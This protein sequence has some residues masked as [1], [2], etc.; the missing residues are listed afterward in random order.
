MGEPSR[1]MEPPR[2]TM[3]R[4]SRGG[5][6]WGE[7]A[8]TRLSAI[9][10]AMPSKDVSARPLPPRLRSLTEADGRERVDSRIARGYPFAM[11]S[12]VLLLPKSGY[13]NEDFL[14]AASKLGIDVIAASDACHQLA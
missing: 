7:S 14:A 12:A 10:S 6:W 9:A 2:Q 4:S 13:R 5:R 1:R 3:R 11:P 8:V